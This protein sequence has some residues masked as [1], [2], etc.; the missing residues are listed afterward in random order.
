MLAKTVAIATIQAVVSTDVCP[1]TKQFYKDLSCCGGGESQAV[2]TA[3]ALGYLNTIAPTVA[4]SPSNCELNLG[5]PAEFLDGDEGSAYTNLFR[6]DLTSY[7]MS[8]G[9]QTWMQSWPMKSGV[10]YH[11]LTD[12]ASATMPAGV[13]NGNYTEYT[14]ALK[15]GQKW[16]SG[17]PVTTDDL[18]FVS[19][20]RDLF[21]PEETMV[22]VFD[23]PAKEY[24]F[25]KVDDTHFKITSPTTLTQQSYSNILVTLNDNA[26]PHFLAD[27]SSQEALRAA[28]MTTWPTLAAYTT[29]TVDPFLDGANKTQ[30]REGAFTVMSPTATT[31][32]TFYD[33][34][35]FDTGSAV[36]IGDMIKLNTPNTYETGAFFSK[37]NHIPCYTTEDFI[38]HPRFCWTLAAQ[39]KL[40]EIGTSMMPFEPSGFDYSAWTKVSD[41]V[42]YGNRYFGVNPELG[43]YGD[44]YLRQALMMAV[45][46]QNLQSDVN[47]LDIAPQYNELILYADSYNGEMYKE[48]DAGSPVSAG[49]GKTPAERGA[50][51]KAHLLANGYTHTEGEATFRDPDGNLLPVLLITPPA[52]DPGR[53]AA[54]EHM[55]TALNAA[56]LASRNNPVSFNEVLCTHLWYETFAED[57][58]PF[59]ITPPAGEAV[60]AYLAGW[61]FGSSIDAGGWPQMFAEYPIDQATE[62][63]LTPLIE[64]YNALG[65]G[66]MAR[67]PIMHEIQD[68]MYDAAY[69]VG[70]YGIR[71]RMYLSDKV[72]YQAGVRDPGMAMIT[73]Y[74]PTGTC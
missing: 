8:I 20:V 66:D 1:D 14:V 62:D 73:D 21:F 9:S 74:K 37:I 13:V 57:C 4:P 71:Q 38:G 23:A 47:M 33:A 26:V 24:K 35:A 27:D 10:Y 11:L 15:A 31:H 42:G 54:A 60:G 64:Q 17:E 58:A 46:R 70:L 34:Y 29:T 41:S 50:L 28:D 49:Y 36:R 72:E 22:G 53:T 67:V 48:P 43:P 3:S 32:R 44:K 16:S 39:G 30:I 18:L 61:G 6:K 59:V 40:D 45:D 51:I 12:P 5:V 25:D 7:Q 2:S 19:H 55:V 68:V 65:A 69:Y 56:G 63:A 52:P